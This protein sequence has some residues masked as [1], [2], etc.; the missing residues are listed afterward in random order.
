MENILQKGTLTY[1]SMPWRHP[2]MPFSPTNDQ[3]CKCGQFNNQIAVIMLG[4]KI[5][6]APRVDLGERT[7]PLFKLQGVGWSSDFETF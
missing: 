1:H 4:H 5:S 3:I 7:I 2:E 6:H